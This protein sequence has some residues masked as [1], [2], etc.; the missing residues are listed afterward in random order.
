MYDAYIFDLDGTLYLGEALLPGAAETLSRIRAANRPVLFLSNNPTRTRAAYAEKL[1]RPDIERD[2]GDCME[3][4]EPN[5]QIADREQRLAAPF[6]PLGRAQS[7]R[8]RI[9]G[10][11]NLANT[12]ARHAAPVIINP[13]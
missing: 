1:T 3:P 13:T 11:L 7:L 12:H 8:A 6:G 9:A 4:A 2:A 10:G 5:A